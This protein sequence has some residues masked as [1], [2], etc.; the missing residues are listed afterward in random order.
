MYY[1]RPIFPAYHWV[2]LLIC[3]QAII[4]CNLHYPFTESHYSLVIFLRVLHTVDRRHT[5]FVHAVIIFAPVLDYYLDVKYIC[6]SILLRSC[7]YTVLEQY[8][9]I[10]LEGLYELCVFV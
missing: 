5:W 7:I 4:K 9:V 8:S 6:F 3:H 1:P 2:E 10:M